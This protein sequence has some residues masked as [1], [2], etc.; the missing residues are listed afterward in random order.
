MRCGIY[1][2]STIFSLPRGAITAAALSARGEKSNMKKSAWGKT[3]DGAPI[4]LFTLTSGKIEVRIT[5][6]GAHLVAVR[7]PDRKG[8]VADVALGFDSAEGYLNRPNAYL[9][10]VVGRYANRIAEGH[11][12]IDGKDYQI[13]IN[14][15]PNA[16]HGGPEGFDRYLWKAEEVS[17][18]V[19]LTHV[20]PDGDM[21]FPGKMTTR[22]RYTVDDTKGGDTLRLD[23]IATTDKPTIVNLTNHVYFNLRGDDDGDILGH[24]VELNADRFT[25]VNGE[26]IP[27]GEIAP[28]AGTP[29]DFR[30]P[31][32]IGGRINEDYDQLKLCRGYDHNFVVN[33]QA[34]SLRR[35]AQVKE[36][37]SGRTMTV[38][39]TEPG[40]QLYTGNFLNGTLTGRHGKK[41][42]PRT[43]FCIETG[44]FPDAPHHA[45]FPS[46]VLRPGETLRSTTTFKFGAE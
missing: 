28:V 23:Y 32:V 13:P 26:Q 19:E 34:G 5:D 45:N 37:E 10:S 43:G 12:A 44:Q 18:G 9:G 21:G 27:V 6:F 17:N 14:N 33:G 4:S 11:F 30:K 31:H 7:T 29:L 24:V 22:V 3:A 1:D 2:G 25:P 35:A 41:Y 8:R 38:E 39:T 40:F 46:T 20:S 36:P 15:G 16:L 42:E